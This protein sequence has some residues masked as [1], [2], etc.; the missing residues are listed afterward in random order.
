MPINELVG[1]PE[2]DYQTAAVDP[3]TL[4]L[5]WRRVTGRYRHRAETKRCFSIELERGQEITI[6]ED[7]SLF[8]IDPISAAI[9]AIRGSQIAEGTPIAVP[10]DLS[11]L[12]KAWE[13][14][15]PSLDLG[16]LPTFCRRL[17]RPWS[18]GREN[19][20]LTNRLRRTRVPVRYPVTD[21]LLYVLGL[22]LAEGG[23]ERTSR[24]PGLAFS[25]GG[26]PGAA[27][28]LQS[29]FGKYHVNVS[30][31]PANDYDYRIWSSV[32]TAV[33]DYLGL[34]G[35]SK[36]GEKAFPP[37]FW[38]LSQRQRRTL[39]AGLWD[40]DGG[41]AFRH[42]SAI[43]QKSHALIRDLYHCF[44][45]DGIFPVVGEGRHRQRMIAIGRADDFRRFVDLYPLRHPSKRSSLRRESAIRGRDKTVGLWKCQGLWDAVS[46]APLP[47]GTKTAI[48]N[49]GGKY[50]EGVRTQRWPFDPVRSLRR[51]VESRLAFLRVAEVKET[52]SK[53]MYDLSVEG[54]ENFLANGILAH[55]SGYPDC[56]PEF[57]KAFQEVARLGTKRGVE[58][59][60]IEIRTPLISMS[61]A[62]IVRKGEELGVPWKLTWS[63]Y[64]GGEKA[65]GVCDSCQLRLKGFKEAGVKDP[66][67]YAR[68]PKAEGPA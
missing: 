1:L 6:T 63:C 22:W 39:I 13:D 29:Y 15:L 21:D 2:G 58:G 41:H 43:A 5:G 30:K 45:L 36:K 50:D 37:F 20:F 32:F 10:F 51:L 38:D 44:A 25:V 68:H 28:T 52:R 16:G 54:A 67:P 26:T 60:V 64:K 24:N 12:S 35:T 17:D 55:N 3:R 53:W 61:K 27:E 11:P 8:T 59:D 23:K 65:C 46:A 31:S 14:D 9:V 56:R 47:P 33:F 49:R 42:E 66:L 4:Q 57:Y 7:H 19:G 18:I 62:D 34:F 40:G 48:Y